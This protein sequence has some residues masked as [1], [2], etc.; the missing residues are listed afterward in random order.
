MSLVIYRSGWV[1]FRLL[2]HLIGRQKTYNAGNVP[3]RGGLI[4]AANHISFFDPPLVGSSLVRAVYFMAKQELFNI[5]GF[6][7][8]LYRVNAFPVKRDSGDLRSMRTALNLL[9]D[10]QAVLIFPEGHR[11]KHGP[12]K[13]HPGIC[14]LARESGCPIIPVKIINT[15]RRWLKNPINI[16]FG[17]PFFI[18]DAEF[19]AE[20][21]PRAIAGKILQKIYRLNY[22]NNP[23]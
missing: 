13:A 12:G 20:N 7:W 8:L 19:A 17:K 14:W 9:K 2:Y 23:G 6:G 1:L 18:T 4:L 11:Q 16:I 15:D 21:D 3:E 22:E 5:P 10:G